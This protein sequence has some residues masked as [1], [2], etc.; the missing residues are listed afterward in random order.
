[1]AFFYYSDSNL[2]VTILKF[3]FYLTLPA[4]MAITVFALMAVVDS[5]SCV[6]GALQS[7]DNQDNNTTLSNNHNDLN[8][9]EDNHIESKGIF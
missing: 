2:L 5:F 8:L 4:T 7:E 9:F 1:M 6:N 3:G